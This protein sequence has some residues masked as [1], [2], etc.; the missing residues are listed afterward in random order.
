[1]KT[2]EEAQLALGVLLSCI[3][4][5][6]SIYGKISETRAEYEMTRVPGYKSNREPETILN[7]MNEAI[8]V[9]NGF[10]KAILGKLPYNSLDEL[11]RAITEA[12]TQASILGEYQESIDRRKYYLTLY[13][14][15]NT[16]PISKDEFD[17]DKETAKLAASE[18]QYELAKEKFLTT[19][20]KLDIGKP[21]NITL[22]S[23]LQTS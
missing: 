10:A 15:T 23:S 17:L 8:S 16:D 12:K 1:M 6:D 5:H 2:L 22:V 20:S 13:K 14:E 21:S 11:R 3:E 19:V 7:N 18:A 4:V 9:V